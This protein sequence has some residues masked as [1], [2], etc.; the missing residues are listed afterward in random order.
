MMLITE[1]VPKVR[2]RQRP[3]RRL[4]RRSV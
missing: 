4:E 2:P 3:S 1:H